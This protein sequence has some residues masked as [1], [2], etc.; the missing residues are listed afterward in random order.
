MMPRI[1]PMKTL[2]KLTGETKEKKKEGSVSSCWN[3][4][5]LISPAGIKKN[6]DI[7][8]SIFEGLG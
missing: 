2:R 8:A 6:R 3:D 4:T 1:G 5:G 7:I